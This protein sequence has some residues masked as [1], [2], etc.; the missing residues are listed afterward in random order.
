MVFEGDRSLGLLSF[1]FSPRPYLNF[2]NLFGTQAS[3]HINLNNV[4]LVVYKDRRLPKLLAK[5]WFNVDQSLQLL[6]QTLS[7]GLKVLG[8]RMSFYPGMGTLIQRFYSSIENG[9]PSPVNPE[10]AREV[11]RIL[12]VILEKARS[13]GA[14]Q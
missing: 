7:N 4:T 8:G 5:S 13:P 6:A 1:S 3:L 12:D 10:D 14:I 11:V 9:G 2:L